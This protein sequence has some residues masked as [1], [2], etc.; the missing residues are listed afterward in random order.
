MKLETK[1]FGTI[2][3]EKDAVI[4]LQCIVFGDDDRH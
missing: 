4:F 3:F 1:N 2:E